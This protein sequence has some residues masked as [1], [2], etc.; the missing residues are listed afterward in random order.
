MAAFGQ[1]DHSFIRGET[2]CVAGRRRRSVAHTCAIQSDVQ[3]TKRCFFYLIIHHQTRS[4]VR[5]N[6]S[7]N[8]VAHFVVRQKR[9]AVRAKHLHLVAVRYVD[10][11]LLRLAQYK[12]GR[13]ERC[14]E[15][16]K[17]EL[18]VVP[19]LNF[20]ASF[21]ITA[22][23]SIRLHHEVL[24]KAISIIRVNAQKIRRPDCLLLF[25]VFL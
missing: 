4:I 11:S 5:G 23:G 19:H 12:T 16:D 22:Q 18:K 25:C 6:A 14:E 17:I 21:T 1:T 10:L 7:P 9:K 3:C 24:L 2:A 20:G 13:R 15:L 8:R